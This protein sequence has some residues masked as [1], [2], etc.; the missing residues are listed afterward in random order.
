[1]IRF[2]SGLAISLYFFSWMDIL[3]WQRIFEANKLFELGIGVY[4]YGWTY[5]LFGF[6]ALGMLI[7]YPN[8]RR[9]ITFPLSLV[10]LAFSG[11]E[12]IL[13]YWMDGRALP[14]LLPWLDTN[15][16][17]LKPVTSTN[18]VLSALI[19][20]AVVII[21]EA[22]GEY[23]DRKKIKIQIWKK[24]RSLGPLSGWRITAFLRRQRETSER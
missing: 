7:F 2:F 17:I 22:A 3:I 4:H 1:M 14:T 9:M 16:L 6:M 8:I 23:L 12:D 19:W 18:L 5:A 24:I 15:P 13:Y 10:L 11:L 20:L 21:F